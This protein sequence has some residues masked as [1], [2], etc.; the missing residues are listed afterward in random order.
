MAFLRGGFKQIGEA[1]VKDVLLELR[2]IEETPGLVRPIVLNMVGVILE[3]ESGPLSLA[4]KPGVLLS[5]YV[6]A[7]VDRSDV[8][9]HAAKIL[10][11]MLTQAGTKRPRSV[12]E[13]ATES[14]LDPDTVEG[15]LTQMVP[16]GLVR[17]ITR[18]DPVGERIWEVSHDFVARL[19]DPIL[20]HRSLTPWQRLRPWLTPATLILWLLVI[21]GALPYERNR[22]ILATRDE[23]ISGLG[24]EYCSVQIK[25]Y[26]HQWS[27]YLVSC[28][29]LRNFDLTKMVSHL[30]KL[31]RSGSLELIIIY[32][33]VSDL[34][35]LAGLTALQLLHL[36]GTNVSDLG[37]LAGLTAL[38]R[39]S[40]T[41]TKVSP[42]QIANLMMR[43]PQLL[44]E[45]SSR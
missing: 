25:R 10:K 6:R 14:G 21:L 7:C 30:K 27:V 9:D 45:D 5:G 24:Y 15:Y 8:R 11:P 3:R 26:D 36:S 16:P 12:G 28:H 13:L 4:S 23:A 38:K 42:E 37:P 1:R 18:P 31:E 29:T 43:L 39:L 44:I 33:P 32:V 35:P 20:Q 22:Q 2:A 41:Q 19:L 34:G 17:R 40:L